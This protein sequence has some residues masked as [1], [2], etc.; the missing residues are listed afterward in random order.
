LENDEPPYVVG[1]PGDPTTF[2]PG[3]A[4][5]GGLT[6]EAILFTRAGLG[7]QT[8]SG[9]FTAPCGLLQV[10]VAGPDDPGTTDGRLTLDLMP[11]SYKGCMARSMRD[12]N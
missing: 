3:G 10:T 2:Y 1:V 5:Q 12:V 6:D 8:S 11:G 7:T 9:G 4:V